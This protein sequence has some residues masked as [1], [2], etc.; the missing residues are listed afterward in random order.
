MP[1][2]RDLMEAFP[3]LR[4]LPLMTWLCQVDLE[5]AS[6]PHLMT[7]LGCEDPVLL[8]QSQLV[9][10]SSSTTW[11]ATWLEQ[12]AFISLRHEEAPPG[13]RG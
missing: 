13:P 1:Y 9:K 8:W 4:L 10:T 7:W 2:S 6:T 5:P 3:Q 11:L 12:A